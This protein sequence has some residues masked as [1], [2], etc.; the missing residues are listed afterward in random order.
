MFIEQATIFGFGKWVDYTID[1]SSDNAIYI[2]GE[3]ESGKSTLHTFILFML[4]GLPP[5]KREF[6][7]PKTSGKLGGR[8]TV[9]DKGIRFTIERFHE[10][11]N[12][13]AKCYTSD[14]IQQDEQW[15][16]NRLQGMTY[17]SY[18][19]VFSFSANDLSQVSEMNENELGEVILGIG[20]TGSKNLYAI[21]RRLD[22]KMGD[23]FKPY[24]KKPKINQQLSKLQDM[25]IRLDQYKQLEASYYQKKT[26]ANNM[27]T[28]IT[29]TKEKLEKLT[30]DR[31]FLGKM[32]HAQPSIQMYKTISKQLED[33][34]EHIPFPE[35][36][37]TRLEKWK[38]KMLPL[39]SELA[40]L[41]D[42]EKKYDQ[43]IKNLQMHQLEKSI[44]DQ[45]EKMIE[46][47]KR[48]DH[49][50][51]EQ[52]KHKAD[53]DKQQIQV[54]KELEE[55]DLHIS[56]EE[57][58]SMALSFQTEK[59]WKQIKVDSEQISLEKE[60]LQTEQ[61]QIDRQRHHLQQQK[62]VLQEK[63]HSDNKIH[64]WQEKLQAV[65]EFAAKNYLKTFKE[66]QQ[67]DWAK[68]RV[69]KRKAANYIL[70]GL[71]FI[72]MIVGMFGILGT[73]TV[74]IFSSLLLVL[75][76]MGQ[77]FF[78]RHS[79]HEMDHAFM[80]E[81]DMPIRTNEIN[82]SEREMI[83]ADLEK[84]HQYRNQIDAIEEQ[85]KG[86]EIQYLKWEEKTYQTAEREKRIARQVQDQQLEYPFLSNMKTSFWPELYYRLKSVIRM[87]KQVQDIAANF[88]KIICEL[89]QIQEQVNTFFEQAN[90]EMKNK[91]IKQKFEWI[92][93]L[94][95]NH[96]ETTKQMTYLTTYKKDAVEKQQQLQQQLQPHQ[97]EIEKLYKLAG[98]NSEEAFYEKSRE[99]KEKQDLLQKKDSLYQQ[100]SAI[101]AEQDWQHM[102]QNV[103]DE[104]TL[105][106]QRDQVQEK[107]K[108]CT[109]DLD[110]KR[111]DLADINAEITSIEGS[112]NI[113]QLM[114]EL[115]F[116]K[117]KLK[118]QAEQ[119][120][121]VKSAK[122]ILLQTK[123]T[124]RNKYLNKVMELATDYFQEL[125]G[126]IYVHVFPPVDDSTFIVENEN[127]T[128]FHLSELS[129]GTVDQLYVSLRLAVSKSMSEKHALPFIIDD[130]FVH[131]D[132]IRTKRMVHLLNRIANDQQVIIFTCK[133]EVADTA[134]NKSFIK[135]QN[136]IRIH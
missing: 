30:N 113:S 115:E 12:G 88:N 31:L 106:L 34:P 98:V 102:L 110:K 133:K 122:E 1:F 97:M 128:R 13:A 90:R 28:A 77:W 33:F 69:R 130:A 119:W 103:R 135:L 46:A 26:E 134:D 52:N 19:S 127:G 82:E 101:D 100:L 111:Q 136:S 117:E 124:Y 104:H 65:D 29:A 112:D 93:Q 81:D 91:S 105:Q 44:L 54:D 56:R 120:A 121:V 21:E 67:N 58:V 48:Y 55:L 15:L 37:I 87:D 6:Y 60:Q 129:K 66:Q 123:R 45:A 2:F 59:T 116:E 24:G 61:N 51:S 84:Q 92:H 70:I 38:E 41:Q 109:T 47:E 86:L 11:D 126:G 32:Q 4:F 76:G 89:E 8:L 40:I 18:Q 5:K 99:L 131:F 94:L 95:D 62:S 39:K 35:D 80:H 16:K 63:L 64:E 108:Q 79:I 10:V 43:K 27:K 83:M 57:L 36:G 7:R 23:L 74:S 20:L 132:S 72:G 17:A 118:Q 78:Q 68:Q 49:L 125:T 14:G 73:H 25:Q 114:H 9:Q 3:N 71:V 42:N 22:D 53:K 50:I 75:L 96:H 85:L 107:M